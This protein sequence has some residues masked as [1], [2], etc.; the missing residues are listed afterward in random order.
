MKP[1][2]LE[3]VE[4][5]WLSKRSL[6]ETVIEQLKQV[7][8]IQHS[9]HRNDIN[10]MINAIAA[11]AAYTVKPT[12]PPIT[13][14]TLENMSLFRTEAVLLKPDRGCLYDTHPYV[15]SGS[16]TSRADS[17]PRARERLWI[18]SDCPRQLGRRNVAER[19]Y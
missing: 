14:N 7:C 2:I 13:I 19:K 18:W 4:K 1:P 9:R 6:V 10:F 15:K 8:E 12:K 5:L 11:L 16:S 3:P 17:W